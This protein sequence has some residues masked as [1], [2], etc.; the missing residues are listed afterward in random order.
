MG[1]V[2]QPLAAIINKLACGRAVGFQ[3]MDARI[4]W[5]RRTAEKDRI[6]FKIYAGGVLKN[7]R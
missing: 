7:C 3:A 4:Q 2:A 1:K 6:K 5:K